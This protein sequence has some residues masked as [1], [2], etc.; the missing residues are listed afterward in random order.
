VLPKIVCHP[1]IE[2]RGYIQADGN[3]TPCCY[4][5]RDLG[6]YG[7]VFDKDILQK[8][9]KPFALCKTCHQQIPNE[10]LMG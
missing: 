10:I 4:D 8:E 9:I 2:G 3:I 5:Y 7:T 6:K 1:L